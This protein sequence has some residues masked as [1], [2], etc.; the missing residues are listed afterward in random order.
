MDEG[1]G[2]LITQV[3]CSLNTEYVIRMDTIAKC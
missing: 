1:I 3:L 2:M